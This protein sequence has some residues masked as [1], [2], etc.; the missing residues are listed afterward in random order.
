MAHLLPHTHTQTLRVELVGSVR[1]KSNTNTPGFQCVKRKRKLASINGKG[2]LLRSAFSKGFNDELNSNVHSATKRSGD[3]W[4][5]WAVQHG[6]EK[7]L[8]C[9]R[10]KLDFYDWT[11][12]TPKAN[13]VPTHG[14]TGKW[15]VLTKGHCSPCDKNTLKKISDRVGTVLVGLQYSTY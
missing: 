4:A 13:K 2:P 5:F 14:W 7:S 11:A 8:R 6:L 3:L 9:T 10:R 12:E 15:R 1:V